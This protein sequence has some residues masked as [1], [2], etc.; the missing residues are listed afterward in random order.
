MKHMF[1]LGTRH[2]IPVFTSTK[3]DIIP[4]RIAPFQKPLRTLAKQK[5]CENPHSKPHS[6]ERSLHLILLSNDLNKL[7][8]STASRSSSLDSSRFAPSVFSKG[9]PYFSSK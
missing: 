7:S 9:P 5:K 1:G 2:Y 6:S 4:A 3:C 8:H